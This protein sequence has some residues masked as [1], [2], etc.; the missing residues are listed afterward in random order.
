MLKNFWKW[1]ILLLILLISTSLVGLKYWEPDTP[2]IEITE[3]REQIFNAK[4][5]NAHKY[6]PKLLD[7]ANERYDS[8]MSDWQVQ[9]EKFIVFRDF[10]KS[11]KF[12][13]E[14]KALAIRAIDLSVASSKSLQADITKKMNSFDHQLKQYSDRYAIVP[15]NDKM[16]NKFVQAKLDHQEGVQAYKSGNYAVAL[17]KMNKAEKELNITLSF[18]KEALELYF[19]DHSEWTK[20]AKQ[21]IEFSRKNKTNCIVVDKAARKGMLY[22][23]GTLIHTYD[24]ELGSNWMG[25]KL[26]QGD[27]ST[28]EGLYKII[29]KKQ[30]PKTK[31][32]KAL[33]LNYPNDEDK[34]R[35]AENKKNGQIKESARIGGLIEIHGN[36]GK[37]AD[38]TEGCI[39]L[40]DKVMDQVFN[41]CSVGTPVT[42]VGSLAP[43]S[44]LIKKNN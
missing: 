10:T 20:W 24:I 43:L 34:I 30:A 33:L 17:E 36:G 31:Y 44:E 14:A 9:N 5:V 26:R 21:T 7:Q 16:I 23:N 18:A 28:P 38:W 15:L 11:F 32:Y 42:I 2:L 3:A 35:F 22:K 8:A 41:L 25:D 4:K 39:A 37:G 12:S 13:R 40:P 29:E 27:K 1:V 6:A 19:K